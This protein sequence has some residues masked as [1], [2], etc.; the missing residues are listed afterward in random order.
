MADFS[1]SDSSVLTPKQVFTVLVTTVL[2]VMF[3]G[4]AAV[5]LGGRTL[6]LLAESLIILPAL[7]YVWYFKAPF[8]RAFRL[9]RINLSILFYSIV[10]TIAVFVLGDELDRIISGFFPMPLEWLETMKSMVRI[11]SAWDAVLLFSTAVVL[12]GFAEEMLFRGLLQRT[13]ENYRDPAIAIVL[14]SV[15]FAMAHFNPWTA[16]QITFLGLVLGYLSWKSNSILPS[17]LLHS[18]NNFLSILMINASEK[19]LA[20]YG[21][22]K[23]VSP[24]WFFLALVVLV[25]AVI[26]F[27]RVC[28]EKDASEM[29]RI[30]ANG[31]EGE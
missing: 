4:T 21:T 29:R 5:L 26:R 30:S 27:H 9:N 20:W 7:F 18:A 24:W 25:P 31:A 2:F 1:D 14:S 16:L 17:I 6:A 8:F 3:F 28:E 12:A 19:Q 23:H 22:E 10:I 11:R 13:L 15:F